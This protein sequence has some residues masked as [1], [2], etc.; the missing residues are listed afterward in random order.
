MNGQLLHK[1]IVV[2]YKAS[3][4]LPLSGFGVGAFSGP[5]YLEDALKVFEIH[6]RAIVFPS[7]QPRPRF[8][9]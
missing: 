9:R 4:S 5:K 3:M 8:V 6:V 7:L 2:L 1:I